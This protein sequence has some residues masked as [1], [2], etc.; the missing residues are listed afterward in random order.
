MRHQEPHYPQ[1]ARG[2]PRG[3]SAR[4]LLAVLVAAAA[5]G[6]LLSATAHAETTPDTEAA[7]NPVVASYASDYSVTAAEAQRR[8]ERIPRLQELMAALRTAEAPR[9]AG[10]GID[11]QGPMTAWVW[12]TGGQPPSEAAAAIADAHTDLQIRTGAAHSHTALLA[13][14]DRFGDGS[15]ITTV[16]AVGNT[17][18]A[19]SGSDWLDELSSIVTF[20]GISLR[21]N[22]IYI[23]ID[24][25]LGADAPPPSDGLGVPDDSSNPGPIG[26]ANE[27]SA[28]DT[29][30]ATAI[31]RLTQDLDSHI[32]VAFDVVDG[33]GTQD[34]AE[35]DGGRGMSSCTSGFAAVT[36]DTRVY[37]ILTAGHCPEVLSM[38]GVSLPWVKGYESRRAD[39]Q[40]HQIPTGSNHLLLDDYVCN[41]SG[42]QYG[43]CDLSGDT[44][45]SSMHESYACHTGKNTGTTCGTVTDISYRPTNDG[46]CKSGSATGR[47][48]ACSSVFVKVEGPSLYTCRGDSGG[49]WFNLGTAYGIHKGG[50]HLNK[51]PDN[52]RCDVPVVA[53]YFSAIDEVKSLLN[54]DI[55]SAGNVTVQ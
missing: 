9:L 45:R 7:T 12:L 2:D 47:K 4:R 31:A 28:S 55:L 16:G 13:A 6:V 34:D 49:P 25:A 46:A 29:R 30:L 41:T 21:S 33:R 52:E 32:D 43:V 14:Q 50:T 22:G 11:H 53:S 35:F 54:I 17:G 20:T 18:Q 3:R 10:W 40:I 44:T 19:P 38:R 37:G 48:I 26:R 27:N 1:A 8:L 51:T 36:R 42:S 15:G 5:L 24:P 23:G 39:A